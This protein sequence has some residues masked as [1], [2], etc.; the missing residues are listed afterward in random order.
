MGENQSQSEKD[1]GVSLEWFA[2]AKDF[3]CD[4]RELLQKHPDLTFELG[5]DVI[6]NDRQWTIKAADPDLIRITIQRDKNQ[7]EII[8]RK[9]KVTLNELNG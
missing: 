3:V 2:A 7:Y 4:L 9:G 1:K 5:I 8:N 6:I